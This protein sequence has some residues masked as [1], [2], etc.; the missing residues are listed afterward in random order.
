MEN[1][2]KT[3]L[4]FAFPVKYTDCR[5]AFCNKSIRCSFKK[6]NWIKQR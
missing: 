6:L 3:N 5:Y 4:I 1:I 2:I